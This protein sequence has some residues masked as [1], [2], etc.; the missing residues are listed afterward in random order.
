MAIYLHCEEEEENVEQELANVT[1]QF[2]VYSELDGASLPLWKLL[3][4]LV[5]PL[6]TIVSTELYQDLSLFED[7]CT[8]EEG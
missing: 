7:L 8:I 5:D 2:L 4:V 3:E 1:S 6:V